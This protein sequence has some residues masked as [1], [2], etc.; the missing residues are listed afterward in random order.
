MP[1][2]VPPPPHRRTILE[3]DLDFDGLL[4][5]CISLAGRLPLDPLLRTAEVLA[6]H[7]GAAGAELLAT[8]P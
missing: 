5:L 4:R 8:L 3:G 7:A 2:F 1:P 6:A